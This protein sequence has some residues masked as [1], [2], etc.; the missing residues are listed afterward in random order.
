MA[1]D[2]SVLNLDPQHFRPTPIA[3]AVLSTGEWAVYSV[4]VN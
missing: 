4:Y 3:P 1:S 2:E